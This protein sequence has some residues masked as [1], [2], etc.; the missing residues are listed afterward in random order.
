MAKH[1]FR[2]VG[3]KCLVEPT[4]KFLATFT[5]CYVCNEQRYTEIRHC[6]IIVLIVAFKMDFDGDN[7]QLPRVP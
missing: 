5:S 1:L 2:L 4:R 7:L 6:S 3:S